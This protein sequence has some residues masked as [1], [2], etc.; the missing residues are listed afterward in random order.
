MTSRR[1]L[2]VWCV[3]MGGIAVLAIASL[4]SV[5]EQLEAI[6]YDDF[7]SSGT[8]WNV[9]EGDTGSV[10]YRNGKYQVR[11][12]SKNHMWWSWAPC[13]FVPDNFLVEV[14]GYARAS[15][16]YSYYGIIWGTNSDNFLAFLITPT[17]WTTV[18]SQ[19]N[20]EWGAS[21]IAW[22]E[23]SSIDVGEN[24]RNTLRVTV[25]GTSVE[26]KV[27]RRVVGRF[28]TGQSLDLAAAF[29]SPS[30][31]SLGAGDSWRVGVTGGSFEKVPVDFYFES[32][33]LYEIPAEDEDGPPTIDY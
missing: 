32:F 3:A 30:L 27:N 10:Q 13:E 26:V 23:C 15:S 14:T 7:N 25:N 20:D 4:V 31:V 28:E 22:Q 29:A 6:C 18:L 2:F 1:S 24:E 19:R 8:G 12:T 5:G 21:P 11:I 16:L 9:Q 17:G 33:A